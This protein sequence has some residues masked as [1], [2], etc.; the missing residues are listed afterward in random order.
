MDNAG[1]PVINLFGDGK[2]STH[3]KG[4]DLGMVYDIAFTIRSSQKN[5]TT[6]TSPYRGKIGILMIIKAFIDGILY[7]YIH[8]DN[9]YIYIYIYRCSSSTIIRYIQEYLVG[10]IPTPLKNM[11]SSVGMM[12]FPIYGTS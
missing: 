5:S 12:K 7:I 1:N 3:K 4:D 11:S 10:G 2:H 8:D 6:Y 9:H